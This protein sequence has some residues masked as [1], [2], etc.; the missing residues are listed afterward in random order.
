MMA[1]VD[2]TSELSSDLSPRV[3][4]RSRVELDST[5][6]PIPTR[7]QAVEPLA[8]HRRGVRSRFLAKPRSTPELRPADQRWRQRR[9]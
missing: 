8:E 4:A 5:E 6:V 7:L 1:L 3:R 9:P 2:P